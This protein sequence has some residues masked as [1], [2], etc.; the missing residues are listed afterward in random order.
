MTQAPSWIQVGTEILVVTMRFFGHEPLFTIARVIALVA[1]FSAPE[2]MSDHWPK[3]VGRFP[4]KTQVYDQVV[5]TIPQSPEG[6]RH[7]IHIL[8]KV[9]PRSEPIDRCIQTVRR[10]I[11]SDSGLRLSLG[12]HGF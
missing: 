11:V 6:R 10:P 2:K 3:N 7:E 5:V 12:T 8:A 4:I 9:W 1:F